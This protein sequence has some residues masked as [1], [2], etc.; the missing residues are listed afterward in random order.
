MALELKLT[1][2]ITDYTSITLTDSSGTYNASTNPTGWGAP[3]IEI[4]DV[5]YAKIFI[6]LGSTTT[7]IDLVDD[8]GIDFSTATASTLIYN[9][10]YTMFGGTVSTDLVPDEVWEIEYRI[11]DTVNWDDGGNDYYITLNLMTYYVIQGQVYDRIKLLPT[12]YTCSDCNNL[13]VKETSTIFM[14]LQAL[15]ASTSYSST[16]QF[17]EILSSLEDILSFNSSNCSSCGC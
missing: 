5:L 3:N 2:S 12:Y 10:P 13:F 15:I 6:T 14:L 17:T 8:L 4:A 9:I 7:E 16:S 1:Q 11:S